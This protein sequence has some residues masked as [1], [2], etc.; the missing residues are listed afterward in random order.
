MSAPVFRHVDP[1]RDAT[2]RL[3]RRYLFLGIFLFCAVA[4]ISFLFTRHA[5]ISSAVS[6]ANFKPGNIMSDY[7]MGN[8]NSMSEADISNFMH[9]KNPCNDSNFSKAGSYLS[10][11]IYHIENG[12]FVC[13]ADETFDGES[14]PHIIYSVAQ[15]YRI[16]P[17]VILVLLEKEQGLISDTFP[18]RNQMA[19]ALGYGC[20]DTTGCDPQYAGFKKQISKAAELFREVLD[21]GWTNYPVGNN[22]VQ[23]HPNASCGGTNVFIENRAT[24]AL[25]RY[26]PYQPNAAAL[27]AG[28][29]TGDA[30]SSYGSRNFYGLFTDWFGSTTEFNPNTLSDSNL[31]LQDGTYSLRTTAGYAMDV[32]YGSTALGANIQ[33]WESNNTEAQSFRIRRNSDGFYTIINTKSNLAL[34]VAGASTAPGANVQSYTDNLTCAQKWSI[35]LVNS[36]YVF[37]NVCSGN[38]LSVANA[39]ISQS[40]ANIETSFYD[41]SPTAAQQWDLVRLDSD[42]IDTTKEYNLFTMLGFALDVAGYATSSGDNIQIWFSNNTYIQAFR[43][44][45][46]ADG[47]YTILNHGG[48]ALD[49]A[50]ASRANGANVQTF[51]SNGT[52]AQKWVFQ[53]TADG[54]Y[55]IRNACSG[56]AM[57]ANTIGRSGV[58]VWTWQANGTRAQKW[59]LVPAASY[60]PEDYTSGDFNILTLSGKAL[61]VAGAST[62]P[63]ANVQIWNQNHTTAQVFRFQRTHDYFYTILT[64]AGLALDVAGASRANGA[65]VQTF[66]SNLTC[67][68]KWYIRKTPEGVYNFINACGG[69][70]LD[71]NQPSVSGINAWT[72]ASNGTNAQKWT[73]ERINR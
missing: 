52:C 34:D 19:Y 28:Y 54:Y 37:R 27:A 31:Y 18:Y 38:A 30:C 2:R 64:P 70:V 15:Q 66:T 62:K 11:G 41:G 21:G 53:P 71:V 9:A 40:E 14:V 39:A 3:D 1:I 57:D 60:H 55:T 7:V 12:H 43:L 13:L 35:S 58:N 61:D 20:N 47:Y 5:G 29:G 10:W 25:Y 51:T 50:G 32:W 33:I 36:H 69:T 63:G 8:F 48:F 23:Y 16:N 44:Q 56:N 26:T 4:V 17:Q 59:D 65:N 46:A 6:Y 68:Q 24:S 73:L 42:G 49:V 22:Y 67:A 45:R 72:W